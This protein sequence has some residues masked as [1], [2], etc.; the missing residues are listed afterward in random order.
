RAAGGVRR[1][2]RTVVQLESLIHW[3]LAQTENAI[4]EP[5]AT[6]PEESLDVGRIKSL[7]KNSTNWDF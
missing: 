2:P 3:H 6:T 4:A 1:K 5:V 7:A